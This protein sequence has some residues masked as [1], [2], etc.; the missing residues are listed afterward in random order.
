MGHKLPKGRQSILILEPS[1]QFFL[2]KAISE[3][4][5]IYVKSSVGL[6]ILPKTFM[7]SLSCVVI[8]ATKYEMGLS[9][10]KNLHLKYS[11]IICIHM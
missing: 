9:N 3:F 5:S 11:C 7:K 6:Q 2:E 8:K 4:H 10:S 1:W